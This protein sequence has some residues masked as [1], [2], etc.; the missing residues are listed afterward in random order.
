MEQKKK[1]L[2]EIQQQSLPVR[3]YLM[4]YVLPKLSTGIVELAKVRPPNP[5]QFLAN[6]LFQQKEKIE[7][8]R[9]LDEDV[10]R[11]F[12]RLVNAS[13]CAQ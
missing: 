9:D 4:K 2:Q 1:E 5:M 7:D 13:K 10:I 11:E 12:Q 3:H 8:D 6:H